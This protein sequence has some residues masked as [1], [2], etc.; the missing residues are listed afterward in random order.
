MFN[1]FL[2]VVLGLALIVP[3]LGTAMAHEIDDSLPQAVL[4]LKIPFAKVGSGTYRKF[5][6]SIYHAT[7]WAPGGTLDETKPYAL[8]L[9]YLRG[10]SKETLADSVVDD[11]RDQKAADDATMTQWEERIRTRLPAVEDG[12]IMIGVMLPGKG[13]RLYIN[14]TQMAEGHDLVLARAF[15]NIWLGDNA[16]E[17]LRASLLH[18]VQ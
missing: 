3:Y 4:D 2:I 15:F 8:E 11:I 5:G 17:D 6:F 18:K 1:K 12:D 10:L 14:G 16:D 7:L 9:H 13:A